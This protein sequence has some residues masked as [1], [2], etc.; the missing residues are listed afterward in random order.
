MLTGKD[1]EAVAE[2]RFRMRR[3]PKQ[4]AE[5]SG[6]FSRPPGRCAL[7][8]LS[9]RACSK[10]RRWSGARS[11]IAG[12]AVAF[13]RQLLAP[14]ARM[15]RFGTSPCDAPARRRVTPP[16]RAGCAA[17]DGAAPAHMRRYGVDNPHGSVDRL[18]RRSIRNRSRTGPA[19]FRRSKLA[20]KQRISDSFWNHGC[21]CGARES[22]A[23]AV[24]L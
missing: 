13:S 16:R 1:P 19:I 20:S 6:G 2:I 18:G 5:P 14:P 21:L 15:R 3:H 11:P 22:A 9:D 7:L 4:L 8:R 17:Q 10:G 24:L 12:H 23:A